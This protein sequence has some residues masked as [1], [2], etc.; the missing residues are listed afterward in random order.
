M[1][2]AAD[3]QLD[4][5]L[6]KKGYHFPQQRILTLWGDVRDTL[7]GKRPPEPFF[8]RA[9]SGDVVEYWQANLVP[10]IYELDD[11]QV[12]T[13]TDVIGQHIHLVKFDVTSSDGA[14]N[15]FNYED[16]T[17]SPDE[18]RDRIDAINATGGLFEGY[19]SHDQ[20]TLTKKPIPFFGEGPDKKWLGAQAT[21]QRWFADPIRDNPDPATGK[22]PR[23]R[24][25]RTVFTHDHLGPSTH[26]QAG[27]YAGLL[28]EPRGSTWRDSSRGTALGGRDAPPYDPTTGKATRDGGPTSW[29]AIIAAADKSSS[30]REFA[31]ELQD[32]QLAYQS[33]SISEPVPYTEVR[34]PTS[35]RGPLGLD[36]HG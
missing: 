28:V 1:Y 27:L 11:F 23:D 17:F 12:R 3:I 5:V 8:F 20:K 9:N 19:G 16:G 7:E 35:R 10:S 2:K 6:N 24:T 30:Y 4:V 33:T 36:G 29:Q 18:V 25:L 15:G 26:Q 22:P 13:P 34:R 21:V 32:S 14:G 31:L